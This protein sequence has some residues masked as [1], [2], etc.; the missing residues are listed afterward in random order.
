MMTHALLLTVGECGKD[1]AKFGDFRYNFA[2]D[3]NGT[4]ED[5][6]SFFRHLHGK[7]VAIEA[8]ESV[9]D[10]SGRFYIAVDFK[11]WN[12]VNVRVLP[13]PFTVSSVETEISL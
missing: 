6:A 10:G 8:A 1:F 7:M 9:S 12:G 13:M 11:D 4:K 5:S 3:E 2:D